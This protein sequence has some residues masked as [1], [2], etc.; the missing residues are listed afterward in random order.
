MTV[1]KSNAVVGQLLEVGKVLQPF[2][3][4]KINVTIVKIDQNDIGF[5]LR[6]LR[7]NRARN[8]SLHPKV[9]DDKGDDRQA[10][11]FVHMSS[12]LSN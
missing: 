4:D 3:V 8:G 12:R 9:G 11:Q 5:S 6:L 7:L 1:R 2:L 10:K